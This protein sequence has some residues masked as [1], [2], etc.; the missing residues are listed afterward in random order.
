MGPTAPKVPADV[1][2]NAGP[3]AKKKKRAAKKATDNKSVVTNK[4]PQQARS[5]PQ[6]KSFLDFFNGTQGNGVG[7]PKLTDARFKL[8]RNMCVRFQVKGSC[9]QS[10]TFAHTVKSKMSGAQEAEASAEF[11]K[12]YG[13]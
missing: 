11:R 8:T 9:T 6:G 12:I 13:K 2:G 4:E 3:A 1:G 10:C 7:W 5:I